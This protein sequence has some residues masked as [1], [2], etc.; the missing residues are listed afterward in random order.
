MNL[1][2][3]DKRPS[4]AHQIILLLA[5][6]FL[7]VGLQ[8]QSNSGSIQ[9]SVRDQSGA[10]LANATVTITAVGTNEARVLHTNKE[11]EYAAEGLRPVVYRVSVSDQGFKP[12]VIENVKVDTSK[13]VTV[14]ATLS[15]GANVLEITV[16]GN[17]S[18]LQTEDGTASFTLG[19]RSIQDMPLNGRNTLS[20]AL[21]LPGASGNAGSEY[22]GIYNNP[23][24]PGRELIIN[25]GRPGT[26][27]FVADG[28]NV[29]SA[30]LARTTVSFTPDTIQEFTVLE[31]NFSAQYSQAGGA[32]IQQTTRGGTNEF[33]GDA[34]EFY[35]ARGFQAIPFDTWYSPVVGN[36]TPPLTRHQMGIVGGGPVILP[37]VYH[38]RNKTFFFASYEPTRVD[39]GYTT[40]TFERVP[41]AEERQGNFCDS[42]VYHS[43]GV[44]T[45]Y[46]TLYNH[47]V[48][49]TASAGG[50]LYAPNPGFAGG[51]TGAL[52]PMYAY[53]FTNNSFDPAGSGC[54][55]G[56]GHK[57]AD[58]S[59]ASYLNSASAKIVNYYEQAN[60]PQVTSGGYAGANYEYF[61]RA[62]EVDNRYSIRIDQVLPKG[63]TAF[64]RASIEP[65]FTN[66]F[67]RDTVM[68][69]MTSDAS[70]AKQIIFSETA[71]YRQKIV[72]N[73]L[74]GY[75]GGDFAR[76]FPSNYENT[77]GTSPILGSGGTPNPLG[78]GIA[79]FFN[80]AKPTGESIG[81]GVLGMSGIQNVSRDHEHTYSISDDISWSIG[82]HFLHAGI[83]TSQQQANE[84]GEGAG[85][86][87]GG[88]W[89]FANSANNKTNCYSGNITI[90]APLLNG[91]KCSSDSTTG[92]TFAAFLEGVPQ[93]LTF[94]DNLSPTY[95]YRWWNFGSYVQDDFKI[96]PNVTL[97]LGLRHQYQSP[98]WEKENRQGQLDLT[99]FVTSYQ[100]LP[101]PV[102][103]F[104]GYNGRSKYLDPPQHFDFEPRFG[105][106]WAL[107]HAPL[108]HNLVIRG[109]YGITHVTLTGRNRTPFPNLAEGNYSGFRAY[110]PVSGNDG[111][112]NYT[113][114]P[115]CGW[116]TCQNNFP[117]QFVYNNVSW[118]PD[119]NL[120]TIP[121]SGI[122]TAAP[123]SNLAYG[124][125]YNYDA[126]YADTGDI[127]AKDFKT[128]YMQNF[129]FQV[130]TQLDKA[131]T[132]TIG[133]Q[134]A[135]GTKLF[136]T[137]MDINNNPVTMKTLYPGYT[138]KA[139][140]N[141]ASGMIVEED[142]THSGSIYH[143]M[144]VNLEHHLSNGLQFDVNYTWSKSLDDS[145][146]GIENDWSGVGGQD[147]G[148]Q[149]IQGNSP[150]MSYGTTN[151]R[152]ISTFDTPQVFNATAFYELPFGHGKKLLNNN[153]LLDY[154]VGGWQVSGLAHVTTGQPTYL[155]LG[156]ED[157]LDDFVGGGSNYNPRPNIVAGVPLKNPDWSPSV[158]NTVPYLNPRAFT[159]QGPAQFGNAPR[160]LSGLRMPSA[161][162]IDGSLFKSFYPF[163][164]KARFVELR[165]EVFNLFNWRSFGIA[166]VS[167]N[168]T[169][170]INQNAV[171]SPNRYTNLTPSVWDSFLKGNCTPSSSVPPASGTVD[172]A[173]TVCSNLKAIYN[174]GFYIL[175]QQ[176]QNTITPR[177]LQVA[178]KIYF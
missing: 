144:I 161:K 42:L 74:I 47:F 63:N 43:N 24:I 98:R 117:G 149:T 127:F 16:T 25:G 23:A 147:S 145:S 105:F 114:V 57:L 31:A 156:D 84:A 102:F 65:V 95:Y 136:S 5:V 152:S 134:G 140:S 18:E 106:S 68:D 118:L 9:G 110:N 104:S 76:N 113:N 129:S 142:A 164:N 177:I 116:A 178:A 128:P 19:Q 135:K 32:I 88:K 91:S 55:N 34:Y 89:G 62:K 48:K 6:L 69:P 143:A 137:P 146:G 82:R 150:Q 166:G 79:N 109:G 58:A 8:A 173:A 123:I 7:A 124:L 167:T 171:G 60:I 35:R 112:Y 49:N 176:S 52:N 64:V 70:K 132:L 13:N 162:Q 17:A 160:M 94:Q 1:N 107:D 158:A 78:V 148:S 86:L 26:S 100:G 20:L 99:T 169:N 96:R 71:V 115:G 54:A 159:F 59:G 165:A 30:G 126:R 139:G 87:A 29:T 151:E 12:A 175:G 50:L 111:S 122:L 72:N 22:G 97:N 131:T 101:A 36:P 103:D 153:R 75:N 27:Q 45:P 168:L 39:Q 44:S 14:N 40:P 41:T 130:Q 3:L 61:N 90:T 138:G 157:R 119:P 80:G 125:Q 77:N 83:L 172:S 33:H 67:G 141:G 51:A 121:S 38:G 66:R 21:T 92:D 10:L 15:V 85:Y 108:G 53:D 120:Y 81:F 170:G 11:G 73:V 155:T 28:Q 93:N 2:L 4:L 133:W 56:P 154:V 46:P 174:S 37:K 163:E